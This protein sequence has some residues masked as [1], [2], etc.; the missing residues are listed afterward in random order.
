V[1]NAADSA[2]RRRNQSAALSKR[3]STADL[4]VKALQKTLSAL[5]GGAPVDLEREWEERQS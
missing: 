1:P 3:R 5:P 2:L 4:L